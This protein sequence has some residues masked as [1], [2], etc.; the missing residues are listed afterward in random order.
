[1]DFVILVFVENHLNVHMHTN[2]KNKEKIAYIE[3]NAKFLKYQ[4]IKI[5]I[6][7]RILENQTFYT[8]Q[9]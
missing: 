5:C 3:K 1:M 7:Y 6:F 9:N 4:L 2:D 8:F